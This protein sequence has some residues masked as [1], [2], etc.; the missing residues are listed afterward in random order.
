MVSRS[1]HCCK[2]R[3]V[4]IFCVLLQVG[5]LAQG[6]LAQG[7]LA[8]T[9]L[10]PTVDRV[11]AGLFDTDRKRIVL[12]TEKTLHI[13]SADELLASATG[14]SDHKG[15]S[16]ELE[17]SQITA[18]D[19]SSDS[20]SLL[21]AGGDPGQSGC[22]ECLDWPSARLRKRIETTKDGSPIAD[23]VTDVHWFQSGQRWIESHWSGDVLIREQ[24]GTQ[25]SS[26]TGHT[27]IVL[28]AI[29]WND[30]F[31]ASCGIDQTIKIWRIADGE[32]VRSL[33]NHTAAVTKLLRWSSPEGKP[34]LI[35]MGR[36]RTLRLW[37]PL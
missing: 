7:V 28:S 21:I 37:D 33:D 30:Q 11:T 27:G 20:K 14:Q 16:I 31:A 1:M 3:W 12:A 2:P 32:L 6:L 29:P 22:V 15:I 18:L 19:L 8:Q 24:D 9:T 25:V 13:L 35:S 5:L 17:L 10:R 4:H 26:F 36:D 34:L 23:V